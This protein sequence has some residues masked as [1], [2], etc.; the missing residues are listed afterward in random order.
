MGRYKSLHR[1]RLGARPKR[2][3]KKRLEA[4]GSGKPVVLYEGAGMRQGARPKTT[5]FKVMNDFGV[6]GMLWE[7]AERREKDAG[8]TNE[9]GF[10]WDHPREAGFSKRRKD[11]QSRARAGPKFGGLR[12]KK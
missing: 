11:E 1:A 4:D 9:I 12:N 3:G 5:D 10:P 2:R 6:L 8:A 7:S